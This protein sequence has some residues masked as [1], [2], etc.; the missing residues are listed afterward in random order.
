MGKKRGRPTQYNW[1]ELE[2]IML[3]LAR[4]GYS[5]P[6]HL[7]AAMGIPKDT[8]NTHISRNPEFEKNLKM[9]FSKFNSFM[10]T[11]I[12][13]Q[14]KKGYWPAIQWLA[15]RNFDKLDKQIFDETLET[16]NNFKIEFVE[17]SLENG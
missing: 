8:I 13:E 3:C 6:S 15:T 12:I 7:G 17:E 4:L 2:K 14:I 1:P 11:K 16:N 9:E 10:I 5:S